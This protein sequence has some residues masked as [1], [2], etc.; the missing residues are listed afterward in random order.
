MRRHMLGVCLCLLLLGGGTACA[1]KYGESSALTA[2]GYRVSLHISDTQV[3]LGL[4]S[5]RPD[6]YLPPTAEVT[7]RIRN[8]QG[9]PIDGVTV[10][11]AVAPA[12]A[13]EASL[14]PAEA[15]TRHGEAR[16]TFQARTTGVV[17][18]IARVDDATLE[19]RVTVIRRPIP[20]DE[21]S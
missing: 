21:G 16:A 4:P 18:V 19:T 3:G 7:V 17:P 13:Q 1:L 5:L 15:R 14:T 9:Q 12:W 2:R 10:Q 20:R 8:A 6:P 11:F